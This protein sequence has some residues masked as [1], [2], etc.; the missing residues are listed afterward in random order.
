L[1]ARFSLLS[2]V[3]LFALTAC[4]STTPSVHLHSLM[5]AT[6]S[7][8]DEG[9][10]ATRVPI[11][12]VLA[13]IGLP[14]QVDQP[15]W[16][17][18]LPDGSLAALEQ[19]RWAAPL[20]DEFRQALLEELIVHSDV[21]E[22]RQPLAG[23]APPTRISVEVRRFDSIL[24]REARI[25][26]SWT[27]TAGSPQTQARHCE[28]LIRETA[29]AGMPALAAAH[30]RA[31]MRLADGIGDSLQALQRGDPPACPRSDPR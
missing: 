28:W 8:R 9:A 5:P 21:V 24:D 18:R 4:S 12:V 1:P 6:L 26:G 22:A 15:Q 14:A 3:V 25:E 29:G 10:S 31:V 23:S 16:L 2:A 13:P 19:E 7:A 27:L 11:S 20:R 30:R 17:V